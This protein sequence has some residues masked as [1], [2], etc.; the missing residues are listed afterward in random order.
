MKDG[1][2][3][4][5]NFGEISAIGFELIGSKGGARGGR[6]GGLGGHPNAMLTL[7]LNMRGDQS[8]RMSDRS[9]TARAGLNVKLP[10]KN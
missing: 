10:K 3:Q 5:D 7:L 6:A 8:H 9:S 1:S 4:S 2:R